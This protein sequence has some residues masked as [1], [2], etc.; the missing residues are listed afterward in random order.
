MT[1]TIDAV[2]KTDAAYETL[3]R[4]ILAAR[5]APATALKLDAL[6]NTYGLGWT[7]LREALSRLEAGHL[8]TSER[9]RGFA[10]APVSRVELEDLQRARLVVELPLLVESIRH[11]DSDWEAAVV[12]AHYRL[13]RCKLPAD[14][15]SESTIS[16][17]EEKHDA[18][19]ESLLQAATSHWLFRFHWQL[20][21]QLRRHHRILTLA[22]TLRQ[23]T[24][25]KRRD[26]KA[27]AALRDAMS[28]EH[29]T[30]L[31]SAA[32]DRDVERVTALLTEHIGF[33]VDVYARSEE[34]AAPRP[35]RAS[36]RGRRPGMQL[37]GR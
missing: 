9:N 27:L 28:I 33:T 19:H 34:E 2:S 10:V 24:P 22:P 4:E 31:M 7:P 14:D 8:V 29:H 3:R 1:Q 25:S 6:R 37:T 35:S 21:D 12:T 20:T 5:L 16:E 30:Q 11:G 15:P 23:A 36:A 13:S 17:W 26:K 18:F 32:L